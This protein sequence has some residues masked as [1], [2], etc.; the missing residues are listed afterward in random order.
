MSQWCASTGF[1]LRTLPGTIPW[2]LY[3]FA[4]GTGWIGCLLAIYYFLP[5]RHAKSAWQFKLCLLCLAQILVV[6]LTGILPGETIRYWMFMLPLLMI[7]V[8]LEL[9]RWGMR[10][11]ICAYAALLVLSGVLCQSMIFIV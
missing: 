3:S 9:S 5:G 1:P 7:P 10:G 11:R 8:G 2:D 4:M 6:D